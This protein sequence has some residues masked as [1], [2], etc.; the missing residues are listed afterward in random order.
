M[1]LGQKKVVVRSVGGGLNRGYLTA[2]EFLVGDSVALLEAD[3]RTK[4]FLFSEIETIAYVKYFNFQELLEPEQLGRRSFLARPRGEGLWLRLTFR[5][6]APLESLVPFDLNLMDS[7]LSDRG[8]HL[9][10]P[11][12]RSNT[13]R[14]FVPRLAIRTVEVLGFV[15]T[16]SKKLAAKTARQVQASLQAGLFEDS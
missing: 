5:E 16:P 6:I 15:M 9:T 1:A 8:L 2:A 7:L 3:G 11:D 13:V 4:T 10:P 12:P 14:L